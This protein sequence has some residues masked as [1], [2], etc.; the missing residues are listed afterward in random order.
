MLDFLEEPKIIK[1]KDSYHEDKKDF[2]QMFEIQ[3]KVVT[4]QKKK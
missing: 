3:N 1:L 4:S 2:E